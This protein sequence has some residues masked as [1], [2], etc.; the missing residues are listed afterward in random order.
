MVGIKVGVVRWF[1]GVRST[2]TTEV[3]GGQQGHKGQTFNDDFE[4]LARVRREI[5]SKGGLLIGGSG[6]EAV[7]VGEYGGFE[8]AGCGGRRSRGVRLHGNLERR[9]GQTHS[10]AI[11]HHSV[12]T[13]ADSGECHAIDTWWW[14]RRWEG[15]G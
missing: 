12:N 3:N 7:S 6:F 15:R 4:F 11:C 8:V 14:R 10:A 1:S 9:T 2:S 5:H 13:G